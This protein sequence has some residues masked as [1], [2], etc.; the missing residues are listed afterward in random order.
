M[1]TGKIEKRLSSRGKSSSWHLTFFDERI[2][3]RW[4]RVGMNWGRA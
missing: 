2:W 1:K 3:T 4:K